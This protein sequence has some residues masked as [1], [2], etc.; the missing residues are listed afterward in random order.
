VAID[1]PE[2]DGPT[3]AASRTEHVEP[4]R[5]GKQSRPDRWRPKDAPANRELIVPPLD[6]GL[7]F[8]ARGLV[9]GVAVGA[10][11]DVEP[12][13]ANSHDRHYPAMGIQSRAAVQAFLRV[14]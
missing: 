13:R 7:G 11:L 12:S 5:A 1:S 9:G 4:G 8:G 2:I 14:A 3:G 6:H 10:G